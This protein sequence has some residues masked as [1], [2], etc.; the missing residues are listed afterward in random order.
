MARQRP[1]HRAA[2]QGR[3]PSP[4]AATAAPRHRAASLGA[5]AALAEH[6]RPRRPSRSRQATQTT[7]AQTTALHRGKTQAAA[8]RRPPRQRRHR[9]P[10]R[11]AKAEAPPHG[12]APSG[13][14]RGICY[15]D[16]AAPARARRGHHRHEGAGSAMDP[17]PPQLD[18]PTRAAPPPPRSPF[19]AHAPHAAPVGFAAKGWAA[20]SA[21]P[22]RLRP[23]GSAGAAAAPLVEL[24]ALRPSAWPAAHGAPR[25]PPTVRLLAARDQGGCCDPAAYVPRRSGE[26]LERIGV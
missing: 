16:G 3:R 13:A 23:R 19:D 9:C 14:A 2:L 20:A 6:H 11:G 18:A 4:T 12:A 22:P 21:P 5:A 24:P 7:A 15:S 25:A 8:V 10:R 17:R 1:R 26:L